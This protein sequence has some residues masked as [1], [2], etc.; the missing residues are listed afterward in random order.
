MALKTIG[1]LAL[2]CFDCF[3]PG[4]SWATWRAWTCGLYGHPMTAAEAAIFRNITG[5][6]K[7][8]TSP[9]DEAYAIK[10][11]RSGGTRQAGWNL[12][13]RAGVLRWKM[14]P[15]ERP[16][17]PIIT[18]SR[19]QGA[20]A[21]NYAA[22]VLD[23]IPGVAITRR[24]ADELELSNGA[25]IRIETASFRTSRGFPCPGAFIDEGG[26]L[27]DDN[28]ANPFQEVLRA[29]RPAL[30]GVPGSLLLVVSTPYSARDVLFETF[31]RHWARDDD[32]I[33]VGRA[34]TVVW[35]PTIPQAVIDKALAEDPAGASAEW[36][37]EFRSDLE[38]LFP[39]QALDAVVIKNRFELAP[40]P[41]TVYVGFID[42]SG[43]SSDSMTLS[44]AHRDLTGRS[45][46]DLL[47]E[48]KPPFSPE[49][50][51]QDFAKDLKRYGVTATYSDSY[52]AEWPR[53][54]FRKHG[55]SVE[56]SPLTRSELYLE[57]VP[58]VNSGGLELLDHARLISQLGSLERRVGRS[59]RD[60]V[61][62]RPGAHDDL[63]NAAAGALVMS[64]RSVGLRALFP[65][66]F[67]EC[68]NFESYAA[69]RCALLARGPWLPNDG[70]CRRNCVGFQTV[71]PLFLKYRANLQPGESVLTAA[72][73]IRER[74]EDNALTSRFALARTIAA[75]NL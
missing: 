1:E 55:I 61:D 46:L 14:A 47:R 18:P 21:L 43:G 59:G 39:K 17:F 12:A 44:I 64:V 9:A 38:E 5:R 53:E 74:F 30:G 42:P 7:L 26:F 3:F 71:H 10:G 11:R 52:A 16:L 68:V 13:F 22:A 27:R 50:V 32:H 28:G 45:I 60:A 69:T 70:H 31:E 41:G 35:K 4:A 40:I 37:A 56:S 6:S 72:E 34:P 29:L 73:F 66:T 24:T 58:M 75:L 67:T 48:V 2:E 8:P 54:Q 36:L 63:A 62:H 20:L 57:C 19:R 25:I 65:S 51:C 49:A 23:A 33:M 15:G